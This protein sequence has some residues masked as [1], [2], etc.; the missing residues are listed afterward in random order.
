M[1]SQRIP[2]AFL[3]FHFLCPL[4]NC[5][6]ILHLQDFLISS[7]IHQIFKHLTHNFQ[8]PFPIDHYRQYTHIKYLPF[9][10]RDTSNLK[11]WRCFLER[12][13]IS[14]R[15]HL[16]HKTE[17]IVQDSSNPIDFGIRRLRKQKRLRDM[18]T[19][20]QLQ[21][22]SSSTIILIKIEHGVLH[23]CH[24]TIGCPAKNI[25]VRLQQSFPA[26]LNNTLP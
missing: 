18:V 8:S 14:L 16:M 13:A 22:I 9:S 4:L 20:S 1:T 19:K 6:I 17:R 10:V 11:K 5:H 15:G 2:Q 25:G 24:R 3:Y 7:R 21:G 12:S 23:P 26:M